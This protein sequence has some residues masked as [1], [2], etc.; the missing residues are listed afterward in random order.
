MSFQSDANEAYPNGTPV[1]KADVRALWGRVDGVV[2]NGGKVFPARGDAEAAGQSALVPALSRIFVTE[3][4]Y[5]HLRGPSSQALDPL[6]PSYPYWGIQ[7]IVPNTTAA[8]N[9]ANHTGTQPI[10]TVD[11]LPEA[12]DGKA[13]Q[14]VVNGLIAD[15]EDQAEKLTF[16]TAEGS[17]FD[18]HLTD[19]RGDLL[20]G[21]AADR[22][23]LAGMD[24][25]RNDGLD[26]PVVVG[27][28]NF[29]LWYPPDAEP[30]Q[31]PALTPYFGSR[32]FG[33]AGE[34]LPIYAAGLIANRAD[35][36]QVRLVLAGAAGE[37][38]YGDRRVDVDAA[39]LGASAALQLRNRADAGGPFVEL[40]L[41]VHAAPKAPGSG[42]APVILSVGDSITHRSGTALAAVYL[43]EWGYTPDFIGTLMSET[44][45]DAPP[46][47]G[48]GKPGHCLQDLTYDV[49]NRVQPLAPGDESLYNAMSTAD[50]RLRNT[51]LRAATGGDD[52][53]DV[54]N[55]Y[56]LDFGFYITR[57]GLATPTVLW[58]G[59]GT[60][61]IRD[62]PAGD[63]EDRIHDMDSL[64]YRRWHAA[65]PS[66]PVVRWMPGTAWDADR[67]LV[68]TASYIPTIRGMLRAAAE[69]TGPVLL[70]PTWAMHTPEAGYDLVPSPAIPDPVTG[71]IVRTIGDTIHPTG[72][73]R[74]ELFRAVAAALACAST[75]NF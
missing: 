28:D 14:E 6:F 15:A 52:P 31:N 3:G 30:A 45:G 22:A 56:V 53:A 18:S 59:Y 17:P 73:S 20:A 25:L 49:T 19:S 50:K 26:R 43:D 1:D 12:L 11:G 42:D 10:S 67:N 44:G 54:R 23:A 39:G 72:A 71:H 55:G 48:E 63:I 64:V 36:E 70:V 69:A 58:Q 51:M 47:A 4:S 24:F 32:L 33:I 8:W 35:V 38:G 66:A 7:F 16:A 57:H 40:P 37:V 5:L 62:I 21:W 13:D 9:R 75:G 60:N 27:S 74:R 34:R 41:T 2:A 68:W 65:Y 29:V 46:V 61:D